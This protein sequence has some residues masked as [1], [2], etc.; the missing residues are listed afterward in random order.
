MRILMLCP[1]ISSSSFV[2]TYPMAKALA[3]KHEVTIVGPLFG[4]EP[5][6]KDD[7][8][9]FEFIEPTVRRP[10]QLGFMSLVRKNRKRLMEGDW[11]VVHAFKLLPHTGPV[12][13]AVAKK[14]GKKFVLSL[15]DDDAAAPKN[16][17]NRW[18]LNR[19]SR[20]Y[21]TADA[22]TVCSQ[23]LQQVYGGD[24]IYQVPNEK[25]FAGSTGDVQKTRETL[26]IG[27]G[28][29]MVLFA[30]TFFDHKGVD[31]LIKAVQKAGLKLVLAGE[32]PEHLRQ[33]AGP[34]TVFTGRVPMATVAELT[35]ACDIYAIPTK[36]TL[37]ARA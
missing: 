36:D 8:L 27:K 15:D 2:T 11:D 10:V 7:T 3:K 28:D 13:A 18:V 25:L 24:I 12:A 16:V 32:A 33:L 30:G 29:T 22:I 31:V 14:L 23:R 17:L 21:T 26:G 6:I 4:R 35:A 20:A 5:F 34:E 19:A 37:Y 9:H 1:L